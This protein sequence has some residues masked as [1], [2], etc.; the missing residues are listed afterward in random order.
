MDVDMPEIDEFLVAMK[1][2]EWEVK[3]RM[4]QCETYFVTG[5]YLSERE[6]KN[7]NEKIGGSMQGI[8]FLRKPLGL[9]EIKD[10]V[11]GFKE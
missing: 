11:D 6:V 1:I 9:D 7:K 8:K 3:N 5:E 4:K 10:I 2:R